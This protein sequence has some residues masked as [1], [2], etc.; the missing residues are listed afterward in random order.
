[1]WP[2]ES[3][4]PGNCR[5][6][7]MFAFLAIA[8][9]IGAFWSHLTKRLPA[10]PLQHRWQLTQEP[11]RGVCRRSGADPSLLTTE[12]PCVLLR[13]GCAERGSLLARLPSTAGRGA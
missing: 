4:K 2:T 9:S 13:R 8:F 7:F 12:R 11:V 10:M 6:F 1:M 5:A 3:K